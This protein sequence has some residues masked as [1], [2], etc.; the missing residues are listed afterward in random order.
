MTG[1]AIIIWKKYGGEWAVHG[2][3]EHV[4]A[5]TTVTVTKRN[6]KTSR[7]Q[8]AETRP[9]PSVNGVKMA[10][11]LLGLPVHTDEQAEAFN[12]AQRE[13]LEQQMRESC[14]FGFMCPGGC[15]DKDEHAEFRKSQARL[16][17][18]TPVK[19]MCEA[20]ATRPATTKVDGLPVCRTCAND[21]DLTIH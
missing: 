5:N 6:G 10:F 13:K 19:G 17:A 12:R 15:R 16:A 20:C 2:P 3:A 1:T 8:I 9:A 7:E 18:A 21:P 11:G 14:G 4:R